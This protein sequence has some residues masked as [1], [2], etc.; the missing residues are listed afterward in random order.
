MHTDYQTLK[1]RQE[2]SVLL[3]TMFEVDEF[4]R[5]FVSAAITKH[6][7]FIQAPI[8]GCTSNHAPSNKVVTLL[9]P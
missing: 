7:C 9:P 2:W 1:F 6:S 8:P 3:F 4:A 5:K